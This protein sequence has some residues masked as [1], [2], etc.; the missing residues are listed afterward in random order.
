MVRLCNPPPPTPLTVFLATVMWAHQ[1]SVGSACDWFCSKLCVCVCVVWPR[2]S[3]WNEDT[4]M[5]ESRQIRQLPCVRR[6]KKRALCF[7]VHS[8]SPRNFFIL[9]R[10]TTNHGLGVQLVTLYTADWIKW[11]LL[12]PV[13]KKKKK[14]VFTK[15]FF[16]PEALLHDQRTRI[17]PWH[18]VFTL[19]VGP[20]HCFVL[21]ALY[22]YTKA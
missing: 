1:S 4:Q 3:K 17:F 14:A 15:A 13:L 5:S 10:F 21:F 16:L 9:V 8:Y 22:F 12:W 18:F 19:A 2:Y 6:L 20:K 11:K 7:H